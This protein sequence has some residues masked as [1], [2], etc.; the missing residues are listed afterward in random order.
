MKKLTLF[1]VAM[2]FS[3]LSFAALNPYAYG[4]KSDLSL[5]ESTLTVNYSLNADA[6]GVNIVILNGETVVETISCDGKTKGNYTVEIPTARFPKST[7]LTWQVEVLG[8]S[9][10]TPTK[11]T[12]E[13][14]FYLPHSMDV[15]VDTESD[16]FGRWYVIEATNGG[17][18]KSGYQSNPLGRGLYAFDAALNPILNSAGTRGFTGG[19]TLGAVAPTN[20]D[21]E[22]FNLYRVATSGGRVFVGRFRSGYA[23]V[24]EA[25]DLHSDDYPIVMASAQGRTVG[26]DVRGRGENLQLA[27]LGTDFTLKEYNLGTAA[28]SASPAQ[29]KDYSSVIV[30]DNATITYDNEGG[31]WINQND[32]N[33]EKPTILHLSAEGVDYDNVTAGLPHTMGVKMSGI[34]VNPNGTELAVV[35]PSKIIIY[36]ISKDLEGKISLTTKYSLSTSR[37]N[38]ALSY[39]YAG[40]LYAANRYSE[41]INFYAMPYD[42]EVTTPAPSKY[43]FE[44]TEVVPEVYTVTV[45]KVGEGTIEGG[46]EYLE[47]STVILK[48][49]PAAHYDFE[50]W[51][52]DVTSTDN[53]LT[54]T[55]SSNITVTANFQE[56]AKYTITAVANDDNMGTV[57][58]GNIYYVGES[59]TL[60]ATAKTGYVFA[61]WTDGEKNATRTITV[62]GDATYT[63]NF[64]A[65]APRAW[66]YDLKVT[67]EGDNYKF[68]FNATTAGTATLLFADIDGNPV[69]PTSVEN[70]A[71]AGTNT[72]LVAKT[73]FTENKDVYWSV[74]MDG[75]TIPAISEITD[76]SKGIYNFYLP[77]GVAVD[78]NPESPTFSKIYIAEST[79]GASDG[80]S[81]RADNQKRG[82]FIYDQ[83]L[84]EL[85]PTS[86]VGVI[87]SNVTLANTT[88]NA[89]KRIAINP[90]TNEV[91]FAY[92]ASPAAVWAVSTEN[93]AGE[94]TNLLAGLGFDYCNSLCFDENGT[95]YIFDNGAGYPAKGSL[96]KIA[97]GEK[98]TIFSENGKYGNADNS[99]ASDG[100]GGIWISQNRGQLDSFNQ[101][102]HVNANGEIDF[103]V[104]STT[105]HDFA[106]LNT[107]RGAMAY[108]P[109]EDI[110]AIGIGASGTIGVSLYQ[111]TYDPST[112]VPSL[113]YIGATP[114][115]GKN[116]EGIA[117]DYA[118]DLYALSANTERFYK[119]TL[120]TNENT[121]TV[122]APSSQK[123]VLGTQCE[124]TVTIND[125][126]MGSVEGAGQHEKGAE[127]TLT[128]KPVAH[129]RF[130]NW[131][132][133]K[134]ST[135]N[136][137]KF[138]IE[139]NVALTANFEA[140]PQWTITVTANDDSMGTVS[141]GGTYDE[142]AEVTITA[143]PNATYRFVKWSDD[144][145]DA[146]R[147]FSAAENLTLQ[148]I[149]EKVPNRAWAYDLSQVADGDNY[150][151]SFVATTA[152]EATLLFADKDGNELV[153]PHVVGAVNAGA[154]TVT[155][156]QSTFAGVTKDVY[157]SV[158]MDGE[159][160]TAVAEITDQSKGIYDF[161]SMRGVVVDNDPN[162]TDFGKIYVEMSLN[163]AS[164][165]DS[166][167]T[168]TQTAGIFIYDQQLN[169]LNTPSNVGYKPTMPS[170]YTELGTAAEAMKR[171]AIN[172]TN[173][174]LAFGNNISGEGSV[175]SVSRNNLTGAA[176]NIIEGATGIDKVNAICYDENGSLYV[177]A[178]VT[179]GYSK[180]NLYKF[181]DGVQTELTLGGEKIFVDAEVAMASDGRGGIWIAQNRSGISQYK[182]L[183]H[184]NVAE[185][186]LD[187]VV[188][189]E[190][191]YSDWFGGNCFRAAVAYNPIDNV[192]AV[193]GINRVS[194]FS[195]SYDASGVPSITKLVQ[196]PTVGKNIDGLAF[197]YAGDLYVVNSSAE[198][199]FK[200]TIPT[201]DNICTVPAPASQKLVLGTQCEVTVNVNDPAMGSVEG[202][203]QH[204]K[205][206]T[207]TLKATANE[208]YQFVNWTKGA[209]VLSAENPYSFIVTEDVTITANFAELPK[210]TITVN[211]NDNTMGSVTGG[212]TV[213]VG[214]SV[215]LTATPNS[216]YAFVK[217]DDGITEATR[218][219]L[220][221]GDKTYTAIFQAMIPR[222]WAY[223]LRMV[224]D[225]DNYKFTFKA[226]STGT[227]TLLFTNKA[228]TPVAP[229]SYAVGNVE[230][231]EKSVTIAKSEFGGTEDIY[232][233]VQMDG[234][235]IENM[236]ELTDPTK[237]I[238]D[239]VAPQGIAVDNNTDSKH[240]GQVY[241]AAATDG[242]VSRGAQTRGIF[243]YDPI[244]NELNSPN[245]GYLPANAT[246]T[247]NTRQAIHRVAVNPTNNQVA[248]AYNI[249]GSSAI[250]SMNPENLAGDAVDLIEGAGITKANSLCFDESGALYVMDNANTSTGGNIYKIKDGEANVFAVAQTGYHWGVEENAMTPDG[251]GGLW[252][253]QNR[254][255]V[256]GYPVLSHV[257][258]NG[259]V[260]FAVTS[261]SPEA[262]KALFPHDDNNASY[263][264]QCAYYVAEDILAFG[265]NKEAVLFKVTYDA[266]NV[267]TNLE[268]IIST[269]KLGTNI[270]GV[271]FDYAG[272]LYVAS[273]T[274][275]RFYK[276][277]VPTNN[278][279]CTVPAPKSQIIMKEAR[280]TVSVVA[281]PAE[282][283]TVTEGGEY[284]AG[285][286]VTLT[287]TA[288]KGYQFVNWT[289]DSDVISTDAS[290]EYTVP[291]EN[292][293]LTAHFEA[294]PL[295]MVGVVKRAVQIGESTIVLT[296]E[297]DG[298]PHLYKVV[299]GE[300]NTEISQ[301]GVVARDPDNAGDLLT[302]SDIAATADGKLI[303]INKM[304][305][306]S[307]ASQVATG[308]KRGE[309]R[310]YIWNDLASNPT[311]WFTSAQSSNWY[312]SIQGHTMAVK[313]TSS[314]ATVFVTGMNLTNGK[315]RYSI[316]TIKDGIYNGDVSNNNEYYHF[317]KKDAI[318]PSTLGDNY[319][320]NASPLG[321][322]NW[323]LDGGLVDPF[324]ITDPLTFNTEVTVGATINDDLGKKFNG[325]TYLTVEDKPL[326][327]APYADANGKVAGVKVIDITNGLAAAQV[328]E[329]LNLDDPAEATA[330]ATAVL[331]DEYGLIITLVTDA[332]LHRL[333]YTTAEVYTRSVTNG[334]FGTICLPYG[335]S[336]MTGAVFYEVAGQEPG[337]V[338]LDQVTTLEAGKPYIF[339]ATASTITVVYEGDEALSPGNHNG[340]Y[341]T[342]TDNTTVEQGNYIVY[343][344]ELR[345][346]GTGCYINA[347]RA[348][349][350]LA[351]VSSGVP[352]PMPGRQRVGMNVQGGNETT[353]LD[354]ITEGNGT[355]T[356]TMEGTYDV[357]GRKLTQPTNTGVYIINGKKVFVVK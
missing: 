154:N 195:V 331:Q 150:K 237:G 89:L 118:G 291:A 319:E 134:T 223:D 323:I 7:S 353:A 198:K 186:K 131:T 219:V 42:G 239:I 315:S 157:W 115:L 155:L 4:L 346:C 262:L 242:T 121:C 260:D 61:G 277:V 12:E 149:F 214:E 156:P 78:N 30:R 246:L 57:T 28:S 142:G 329:T 90:K 84:A 289:I 343:N 163:G 102:S 23:P 164:D 292:V 253:A 306:Q 339:R 336:N 267:P 86:N 263:R 98:I 26:L 232:W 254:W 80:G 282:M 133:D 317:T 166:E 314:N 352:A 318:T 330:A 240:F 14:K 279:T 158:K 40:N 116:V 256:D 27:L 275:K 199:L 328:L 140:T 249:S 141:G 228:G 207:V 9:V 332:T 159:E 113:E 185:D 68:T 145:T 245:A 233:S 63:A 229:T 266:N 236:V 203:G 342:F 335:S 128:A 152:G 146:T 206:A 310:V 172:P 234:A 32:P 137:F 341:G 41:R 174:N 312:K 169:E 18:T 192:L 320:L 3:T 218:T 264:G 215:T 37:D 194:L 165:G 307:D 201:T 231:G 34:A 290:F 1:L 311:T 180:F 261:S 205:D 161:Y 316:Y 304:V 122:P 183:S 24:L 85:N 227:A 181:T 72:I 322:E 106:S 64:Q 224:E 124:V 51:T 337:K 108:N 100:R 112:G 238:Y 338:Y 25:T 355:I 47:N 189:T 212:G 107:S 324:E 71:V 35:S 130:V 213:Y 111:V 252:I 286:K 39:D 171:L 44:L 110:L 160:I 56:H 350:K 60:K 187:F 216:G 300:L 95:L 211:V 308:Y 273:E 200:F 109:R 285:E 325:A 48:A 349:L 117:F 295:A 16:Y 340:L 123:L 46:G 297:A 284:K 2:L 31:M 288:N 19:M 178:N 5:D 257:D 209:E 221:E 66:A 69:V 136:P 17:Q 251:R 179:T 326:M 243:V 74:K 58:G 334:D 182:I 82:I 235:A 125:P 270:D 345:L 177:L 43:A 21:G 91:A 119:F 313:G 162:S 298:T 103:E 62:S 333:E 357:L 193:Q 101:L 351:D 293:T 191:D 105:P 45:E 153:A 247:S 126:A 33:G 220:V 167:R 87:P 148:A 67:E 283:G 274:T 302:I 321:T 272:D 73:A 309:T 265:G 354:N 104:N 268:K 348:Y 79:D 11:Q 327:V 76:A 208:H 196:T 88:R 175:W 83:T 52:G 250:W 132:G 303:A 15:D 81:D 53:P 176:T 99:L 190:K 70:P 75:A 225:G 226:T 147:T 168:K 144:V 22:Y 97:N 92:N 258:K 139:G 54:L 29:T 202:A 151:F 347:Y 77:Q 287:A 210:Y 294:K 204:E 36:T 299:D 55:V 38:T 8:N 230:A 13:F 6:T 65:I 10:A 129:H 356:P 222:A 296:H 127:V 93:V 271:A 138:T 114:S 248:F 184:V 188:E 301:V 305:C 278:N 94:A 143:T 269:G 344:N 244:L 49:T 241:V 20:N 173:G 255:Q 96:Y 135:D 50:S 197:D 170:S 276:F 120:P 259:N 280:Y 59:V 217:W 281:N